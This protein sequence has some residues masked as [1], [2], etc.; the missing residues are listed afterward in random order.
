MGNKKIKNTTASVVSGLCTPD[1]DFEDAPTVD[2]PIGAKANVYIASAS[3]KLA[4][5]E[6]TGGGRDFMTG[7]NRYHNGEAKFIVSQVVKRLQDVRIAIADIGELERR[8]EQEIV[9]YKTNGLGQSNGNADK[10]TFSEIIE[11]VFG[12]FTGRNQEPQ[13]MYQNTEEAHELI[14]S[15]IDAELE[16]PEYLSVWKEGGPIAMEELRMHFRTNLR[17]ELDAEIMRS[18]GVERIEDIPAD[19]RQDAL[20]PLETKAR[21][22]FSRTAESAASLEAPACDDDPTLEFL[23]SDHLRVTVYDDGSVTVQDRAA[24]T[25][26]VPMKDGDFFLQDY[27]IFVFGTDGGPHLEV[28][29]INNLEASPEIIPLRTTPPRA[30]EPSINGEFFGTLLEEVPPPAEGRPNRAEMGRKTGRPSRLEGR[31]MEGYEGSFEGAKG[32]ESEETRK[33]EGK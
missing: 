5:Q 32:I 22:L 25:D 2:A 16:K 15:W 18:W 24:G 9:H 28:K 11:N 7:G 3:P 20:L 12:M 10:G 19:F 21:D 1:G 30:D 8:V 27:R 13:S 29:Q 6:V 26:P 33:F 14:E 31:S 17:T 23:N 4:L